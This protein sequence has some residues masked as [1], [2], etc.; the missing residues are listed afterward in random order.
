MRH[1]YSRLYDFRIGSSRREFLNRCYAAR[2]ENQQ[3]RRLHLRYKVILLK[4]R[5]LYEAWTTGPPPNFN[6]DCPDIKLIETIIDRLVPGRIIDDLAVFDLDT[7]DL[8]DSVDNVSALA[9][10]AFDFVRR[11]NKSKNN[12]VSNCPLVFDTGSSTGLSH[13]KSDFLCY[14]KKCHIG[15]KGIAG[16]RS[17]VGGGTILRKFTTHCG[18]TL[19]LPAHGYHMPNSYI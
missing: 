17:I 15:A 14:Y 2:R 3:A 1:C 6:L 19:Y 4:D 5:A 13:F 18:T 11:F 8:E 9:V 12:S 7:P 10:H 16:G